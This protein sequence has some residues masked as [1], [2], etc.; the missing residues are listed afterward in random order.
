LNTQNLRSSLATS[1]I[2]EEICIG[3][4]QHGR[5]PGRRKTTRSPAP[6]NGS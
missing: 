1:A 3:P 4:D 6:T 2:R 5:C